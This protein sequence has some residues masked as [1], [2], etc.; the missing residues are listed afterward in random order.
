MLFPSLT[1]VISFVIAIV[2]YGNT[3]IHHIASILAE[4]II[5]LNYCRKKWKRDNEMLHAVIIY[6]DG[7]SYWNEETDL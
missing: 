5:T 1:C 6:M 2:L 3:Q 7:E 4:T